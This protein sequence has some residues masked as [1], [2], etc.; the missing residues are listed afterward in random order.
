MKEEEKP[1]I[2]I[3][4]NLLALFSD[5]NKNKFVEAK[6]APKENTQVEKMEEESDDEDNN[7]DNKKKDKKDSKKENDDNKKENKKQQKK[8]KDDPE[9]LKRTLFVGNISCI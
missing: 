6:P 9:K 5:E 8:K 2:E 4:N 3:P 1:N 7:E